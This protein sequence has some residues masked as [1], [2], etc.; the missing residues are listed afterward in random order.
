MIIDEWNVLIYFTI[1]SANT[2]EELVIKICQQR[3]KSIKKKKKFGKAIDFTGY[4]DAYA[5]IN[6]L[7]D[8]ID[9]YKAISCIII[10]D[11]LSC[12]KNNLEKRASNCNRKRRNNKIQ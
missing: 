1:I 11:N 2:A 5:G 7:L 9:K 4:F 3:K 8:I 12:Q 6:N 10:V